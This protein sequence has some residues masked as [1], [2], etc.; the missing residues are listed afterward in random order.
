MMD[1]LYNL[2]CDECSEKITKRYSTSFSLGILLFDKDI[3]R[4]IY[5]IYG[6]VRFA[7]EIVD[8]YSGDDK[9]ALLADFRNQTFAAIEK[10]VSLNPVLHSFQQTVNAYNIG[11]DLIHAFLD[12]MEMDIEKRTY[13]N[14]LLDKYVYGSAEVVGLMCLNVFVKNDTEKYNTLTPYARALGS[15]FQKVNFL[16]DM[17]SDFDDRGRIYFPDINFLQFTQD[18]KKEIENNIKAEFN[19]AL[20]GIKLLPANCRFGVYS[21]YKYYLRLFEKIQKSPAEKIKE[22]RLRVNNTEKIYVLTKS[23][24][25]MGLGI[26]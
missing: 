22:R 13:D 14:A 4:H 19:Q 21:A 17:K 9:A 8:T 18:D 15:A 23:W 25:R 20:I 6:F 5:N 12:S 26:L 16:R 2:V 24:V 10:K 11:L 7:D 1:K 3:R